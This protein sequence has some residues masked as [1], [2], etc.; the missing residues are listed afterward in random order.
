MRLLD[1]T[2]AF[3]HQ[4]PLSERVVLKG[5]LLTSVWIPSRGVNDLDFLV[6]GQWTAASLTP[7]LSEAF[8]RFE[9]AQTTFSV[10][11]EETVSPGLRAIVQRD[12]QALQVDFGFNE[13]LAMA[14]IEL[15]VRGRRVR[16]VTPEVMFGWK[17]H[18]LVEHG[19][20]GRWHAKTLSDL[21]L[22]LRHVPLRRPE[23]RR[24]IE[25]AFESQ[26]MPLT[27]LDAFFDDP[28]WGASRGSRNKWKSYLKKSPW[29][30]GRLEDVLGE[31]RRALLPLIR[32]DGPT[33]GTP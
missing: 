23:A 11:W 8:A 10:I 26:R 22:F 28:T 7:I 16:T 13:L 12:G 3:V 20:R 6:E 5:S 18:S 2:L 15:E 24:S 33:K 27:R 30:S 4:S 19:E 17:V 31:V 21:S 9:R 1:D 14:P 25:A 32:P 29:A